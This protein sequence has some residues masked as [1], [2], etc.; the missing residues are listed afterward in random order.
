VIDNFAP[1]PYPLEASA[2]GETWTLVIGW[3]IRPGSNDL[4]PLLALETGL[5]SATDT[6]DKPL[7]YRPADT[8]PTVAPRAAPSAEPARRERAT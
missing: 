3:R 1:Q 6:M 5:T 8:R 7:R 4:T 2:D